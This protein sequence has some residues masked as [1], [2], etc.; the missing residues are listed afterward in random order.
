M[1]ET[2]HKLT[3]NDR[4]DLLLTGVTE[5]DSSENKKIVLK[6]VL[7]EMV[8]EGKDLHILHL[9]LSKGESTIGGKIDSLLYADTDAQAKNKNKTNRNIGKLFK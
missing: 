3:L 5:V 7:G 4:R 6:T 1:E 2:V 9:D 8:V